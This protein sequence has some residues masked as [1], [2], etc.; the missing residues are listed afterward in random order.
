MSV[1]TF[2]GSKSRTRFEPATSVSRLSNLPRAAQ[3]RTRAASQCIRI[4][5]ARAST[6][7]RNNILSLSLT[8]RDGPVLCRVAR[9]ACAGGGACAARPP[10]HRSRA[11]RASG[12][13]RATR[14]GGG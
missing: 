4:Y 7:A 5:R 6:R 9:D 2:A 3:V 12:S 10:A 11:M 13:A 14:A 8:S 1:H